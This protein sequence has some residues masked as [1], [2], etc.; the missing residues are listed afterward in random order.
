M[1]ETDGLHDLPLYTSFFSVNNSYGGKRFRGLS[2]DILRRGFYLARWY[3]V[4]IED[5][6]DLDHH[7]FGKWSAIV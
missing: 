6:C 1:L 2:A 4:T 3:G 7:R 5:I